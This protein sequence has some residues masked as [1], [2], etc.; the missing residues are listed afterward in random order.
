MRKYSKMIANICML[1]GY[2]CL[3]ANVIL[4]VADGR[5]VLYTISRLTE[6]DLTAPSSMSDREA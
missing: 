2:A 6:R 3:G 4:P 1:S 5:D